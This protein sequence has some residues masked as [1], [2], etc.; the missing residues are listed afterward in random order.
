MKAVP[1]APLVSQCKT[2]WRLASHICLFLREL[3]FGTVPPLVKGHTCDSFSCFSHCLSSLYMCIQ[4]CLTSH[5]PVYS[6]VEGATCI[7][8]ENRKCVCINVQEAFV[9][10]FPVQP[11]KSPP[12]SQQPF[13]E[14]Y[15]LT[16]SHPT[17]PCKAKTT[18]WETSQLV[19]R[20]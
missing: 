2:A 1:N 6:V 5:G 14:C 13:Q 18:C 3:L 10:E 11:M 7:W 19:G 4:S 12:L 20:P 17:S 8:N 9:T 15:F 16:A